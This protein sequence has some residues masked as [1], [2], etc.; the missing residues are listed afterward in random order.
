M[1][2]FCDHC[3][4]LEDFKALFFLNVDGFKTKILAVHAFPQELRD[5]IFHSN[6]ML[7]MNILFGIVPDGMGMKA[8]L[9]LRQLKLFIPFGTV[10]KPL[11]PIVQNSWNGDQ[12]ADWLIGMEVVDKSKR[13]II[14]EK[15]DGNRFLRGRVHD[16]LT[17]EDIARFNAAISVKAEFLLNDVWDISRD[18]QEHRS[19]LGRFFNMDFE[20][21]L[22]KDELQ[23]LLVAKYT[24]DFQLPQ[25][26]LCN[27]RWW[28]FRRWILL[29]DIFFSCVH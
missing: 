22:S 5:E 25:S 9:C 27:L 24:L 17:D 21:I 29:R 3:R 7:Y 26:F 2:C 14:S 8:F 15:L 10:G 6:M 13:F 18:S 28:L 16:I 19:V 1:R 12:V 20:S 23:R 11:L 4:S